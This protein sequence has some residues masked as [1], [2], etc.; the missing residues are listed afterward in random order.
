[1]MNWGALFK[2]ISSGLGA[3]AVPLAMLRAAKPDKPKAEAT[4][5]TVEP[6][7]ARSRPLFEN[8]KSSARTDGKIPGGRIG[9]MAASLKSAAGSK[10]RKATP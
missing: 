10:R 3:V 1:M 8:W 9:E 5:V 7:D 2:R 4:A 6:K